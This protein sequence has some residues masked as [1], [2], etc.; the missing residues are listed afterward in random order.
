MPDGCEI[1]LLRDSGVY[2]SGIV[3]RIYLDSRLVAD[4]MPGEKLSF[5]AAPGEHVM[6][7]E[8]VMLTTVV[9]IPGSRPKETGA[10]GGWVQGRIKKLTVSIRGS[11]PQS[12]RVKANGVSAPGGE[13]LDIV[14]L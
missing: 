13:G 10:Q 5:F 8:P 4:V 3:A 12:F 14:S 11:E 7:F 2:L 1:V 6:T 9:Q